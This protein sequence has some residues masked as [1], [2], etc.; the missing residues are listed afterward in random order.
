MKRFFLLIVLIICI[1]FH[2]GDARAQTGDDPDRDNLTT[3]EEQTIGTDPLRTDTDW[4]GIGDGTEV[5]AGTDPLEPG[6][7]PDI[8][9]TTRGLRITDV[10]PKAFSLLWITKQEALCFANVYADAE[11]SN[12][13]EGLTITDESDLHPPA[14][15]KGVMKVRVSGL[16][17]QTTYYFRRVTISNGVVLV[18]PASRPLPSVTT[19]LTSVILANDLLRH[20]VWMSDGSTPAE[21]ALLLAEV[22]GGSYPITGWVGDGITAPEVL[23]NLMNVYSETEH[24]NLELFG[25]EAITLESI[26]GSMGF[27]RLNGV[28]PQEN[29]GIQALV[30]EPSDEECTLRR[31]VWPRGLRIERR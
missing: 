21:G 4:D 3:Q 27:R 6:S 23:V 13:I 1:G 24:E 22:E 31:M 26:G 29:G 14:G 25:G 11:G 19:E 9:W 28:V 30:P 15:Q 17:P 2:A 20:R 8:P 12:V 10:T 7:K 16:K 5:A 18:E